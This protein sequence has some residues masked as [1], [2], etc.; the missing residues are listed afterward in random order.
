MSRLC[1]AWLFTLTLTGRILA[2][3]IYIIFGEVYKK[4]S[5]VGESIL[6]KNL[7]FHSWL[8]STANTTATFY[9]IGHKEVQLKETNLAICIVKKYSKHIPYNILSRGCSKINFP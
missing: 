5:I 7:R 4:N 1:S 8:C 3:G 9:S 2:V 6:L